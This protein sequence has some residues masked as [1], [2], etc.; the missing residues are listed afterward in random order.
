MNLITLSGR[1]TRDAELSTV[2][3]NIPKL[4]FSL[5]VERAYQKDKNN[6]VVDYI[7][8]VVLGARAEKLSHYMV[9]GKAI[10]ATGELNIDKYVNKQG[11]TRT[12]T[13]V[14]VDRLEFLSSNTTGNDNKSNNVLVETKEVNQKASA[15]K[16]VVEEMLDDDDVP[17]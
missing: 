10:L 7:D 16:T 4:K 13:T 8:C 6:K 14:K 9:K 17:F 11:E 3:N 15:P 2:G 12:A 1:L 5:A